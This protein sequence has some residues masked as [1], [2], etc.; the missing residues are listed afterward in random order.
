MMTKPEYSPHQLAY[1]AHQ[2][3]LRAASDSMDSMAGALLDAQVDLNPHQIDAALFASSNP[4]SKGVILADEV[5]LG[6]TIEAGLLIAQ[7][8]AERKRRILVIAPANLRKQWHQ[9][10]ADKFG[11]TASILEAKSFKQAIKDGAQNPFESKSV[12]I[13]SYQF[14]AGK[15][16]ELQSVPWDLVVIDE[17]HRL[18]NVYKPDNKTANI[19][20]D[21]LSNVHKVLLTATPLQ[22]SLLELYGLVSI[23]DDRVFGDLDSFKTQF[24]QLK[25]AAS[26][27]ALKSRIQPICKRT[28]RRQ[29]E[30][31]VKYTRRI[32]M[33]EEFMPGVD[34]TRLYNLVSEYLQRDS[35]FALPNSQRQLITLVLRKLLASSTFAIAG[36]LETLIKRLKQALDD[37]A[38]SLDLAEEL[39]QDFEALDELAEETEAEVQSNGKAKT[40]GEIVAIKA[41][42]AELESFRSL[43]V[44]IT[45][46]A[47]GLALLQA[48]KVAFKKLEELGAAKKAIIFTESRRTQ[49]YLLNL[50]VSTPE[51]GEGT[52]GVVLF[53]GTNNDE[54]SR[55]I[56]SEWIKRHEGTDRVTG[57]RTADTRAALVDYFRE[58]GSL[59]IATE[60]GAEGI[61]LQ[62]CSMVINYDL[63]WNPQRIEQRIGRCHR[64]GQKH[65][66]VV[67]NFLNRENEADKRVYELL[68][69]KFQLFD[70]VFGA[71][72]EVLGAVESGVDF[73]RR[74]AE[75]YQTCRH[76]DAIH[77]AFQQLQ[78]DLA[79]EINDAMINAR[80]SLLENFDEDVQERLRLRDQNARASLGRLERLLMRFTRAALNGHADFDGDDTGFKLNTVPD[81]LKVAASSSIPLGRYEL[82]R[83][84]EEAHIYRMAHPL[85]QSLIEH[86]QRQPLQPSKLVFDYDAYGSKVSV[87]EELRG[88][89]GTLLVQKLKVQSLGASE[90]HMLMAA[91][92]RTSNIY[93]QDITEKLLNIPANSVLL[94]RLHSLPEQVSLP[95]VQTVAEQ[96]ML[97][98]AAA[99]VWV[100][101]FLE[102]EISKQRAQ[103]LSELE[104]R[105]LSFFAQETDKLDSWADDLKVGLEREIKELDRQIKE[106][107]TKSKG[108]ATL[109]EKLAVQKEQRD[110]EGHRDR[111]RRELFQRQDEIQTRRD[112][113]I[114]ELE[115]QL[116]QQVT[117]KP[118]FACEWEVV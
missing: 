18:R 12:L 89:S 10:L 98:F 28:L 94:P 61:N 47:K 26:F 17:A 70:G 36:A 29:V 63:P 27:D 4:L 44:S 51:F 88:K 95:D 109:A 50:L 32:P 85:A 108:V 93:D 65:D 25:D 78:L 117:V 42:I 2:L 1:F 6:K 7:R 31:Y 90:E 118:L 60:A 24:G 81:G 23:V 106:I 49:D 64:Y 13:C 74:I 48:L 3:T 11:I 68:A 79:G 84:S 15:A 30:A 107:R 8:W 19:L 91:V 102:T 37:K 73:E 87:V 97:D 92:D 34:E 33:L 58:Q 114:D 100:P 69:Q 16:K 82:P 113:L 39:D 105:N 57:S 55:R 41:E 35:L 112:N 45:E 53:N 38:A 110:L 86:A 111:K 67:V 77:T 9:E 96:N 75:I 40:E 76:P 22:N 103:I 116:L 115:T 59:M 43:A 20:R 66:V 14:A 54:K 56:Y 99:N 52:P 72:D 83:R 5:G 21:A 62:F 101:S 80:K 71:S 46:N 104:T